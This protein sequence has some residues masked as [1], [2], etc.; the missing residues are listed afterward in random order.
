[1]ADLVHQARVTRAARLG[2]S[3]F[4]I[5]AKYSPESEICAIAYCKHAWP[6]AGG[7]HVETSGQDD[8]RGRGV[9]DRPGFRR[10]SLNDI[11]R[12]LGLPKATLL[13][14][15]GPIGFQIN[16]LMSATGRAYLAFC[17]DS[18]GAAVLSGLRHSQRPGEALSKDGAW[19]KRVL[20]LSNETL[21]NKKAR[22]SVSIRSEP[23]NL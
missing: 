8:T 18:E 7:Q 12:E 4:E 20:S 21:Q 3:D 14:I 23:K 15:L 19:V 6:A 17:S 10:V 13:R 9:A 16:M 22:A 11:H 1:L 2:G 5:A